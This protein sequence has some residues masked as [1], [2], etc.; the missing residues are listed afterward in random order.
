MKNPKK[1][2]RQIHGHM[3]MNIVDFMIVLD[4]IENIEKRLF[5]II[6]IKPEIGYFGIGLFKF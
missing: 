3:V 6:I 1:L 2:N 5:V 4:N